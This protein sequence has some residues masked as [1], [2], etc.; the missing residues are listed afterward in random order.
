MLSYWN[1]IV[2]DLVVSYIS[3]MNITCEKHLKQNIFAI[4]ALLKKQKLV[5]SLVHNQ[6]MH[7]KDLVEFMVSRQQL[8]DLQTRIKHLHTGDIS[9]L[10]EALII[11][12]RL[13]VWNLLSTE[14]AAEVLLESSD[15]VIDS[16]ISRLSEQE[17]IR[18]MAYMDADDLAYLSEKL[19]SE[20]MQLRLAE[21]S[22]D[23]RRWLTET[24]KYDDDTVGSFMSNEMIVIR[25][26]ET[27]DEVTQKLRSMEKF[28]SQ[29]DKLFVVDRRGILSGVLS[30]EKVL[31][32]HPELT[33]NDVMS[34]K[35]V[36][37][38]PYDKA[39][40]A[41]KAFERYDLI[42]SPVI[43]ERGKILGRV[44]VEMVMDNLREENTEDVLNMV[45]LK[46]EEGLFS[47]VLY[48]VKSRI[49]WLGIN[50]SAAFLVSRVIGVFEMTL[51]KMVSLA[52]LMPIVAA[53]GGNIGNQTAS[54]VIR[55]LTLG[56]INRNNIF[57]LAR[58]EIL[59]NIVNGF[60]LGFVVALFSYLF[61]QDENLSAVIG[62]AML[63]NL[64]VTAV[65]GLSVPILL[66]K[67]EFDP[68]MGSSIIT[69]A[70]ADSMG[71]LI[72]LGLATVFLI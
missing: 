45:G 28:P 5:Q 60:I 22:S 40:D 14:R 21:L 29:S 27:I 49:L 11:D 43:N 71:F 36:T 44:T 1:D 16:I 34:K 26:S 72:F 59:I 56:T 48:S 32:S 12:E 4:Q 50:L 7:K 46:A 39:S 17:I 54:L 41:S 67:F 30:L 58:K 66:K 20:L 57:H 18:L 52:I 37:F 13:Q 63:L 31:L 70:T 19:P 3:T 47:P 68:A 9:H 42:S 10:L 64:I 25:Q 6:Q 23:E 55:G 8:V 33:I 38:S 2:K 69:T 62:I 24:R 15:T 61:Y 35:V 53:V 65:I 51:T